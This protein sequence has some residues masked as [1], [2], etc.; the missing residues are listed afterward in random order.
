MEVEHLLNIQ[1]YI[2]N[3]GSLFIKD[4]N[5]N[6]RLSIDCH[7]K[8]FKAFGL[9]YKHY[10]EHIVYQNLKENDSWILLAGGENPTANQEHLGK[11]EEDE[12]VETDGVQQTFIY[13]DLVE[14]RLHE[15]TFLIEEFA[16]NAGQHIYRITEVD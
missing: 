6:L 16:F 9:N 7:K 1:V 4:K 2:H 3:Y 14:K 8:L 11:I 5:E 15:K 10:K 12:S 13:E